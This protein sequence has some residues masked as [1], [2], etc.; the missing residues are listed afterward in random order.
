M[1]TILIFI[2]LL[3]GSVF[4]QN[5]I[6]YYNKINEA[7]Y[8]LLSTKEYAK[9]EALYIEA[10]SLAKP[11]ER[12]YFQVARCYAALGDSINMIKYLKLASV[13]PSFN[14]IIY[15][16]V[17]RDSIL[18]AKYKDQE[19]FQHFL[20]ETTELKE[21][22]KTALQNDPEFRK[23]KDTIHYFLN[24]YQINHKDLQANVKKLT[25]NQR[26]S[27]E[28]IVDV[29]D[30]QMRKK[31]F[32][33]VE[34]NGFPDFVVPGSSITGGDFVSLFLTKMTDK[35]LEKYNP[36]MLEELKKGNLTPFDYA[37]IMDKSLSSKTKDKC[38][39]YSAAKSSKEEC[40]DIAIAER[41]KIGL[42]IY[43]DGSPQN[44]TRG[45]NKKHPWVATKL[46]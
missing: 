26:D 3:S 34:A 35:E 16:R 5:Y 28:K 29:L 8:R 6:P 10:F 43:L 20:K 36:M 38:L 27:V 31:F 42:S 11:F 21:K 37:F 1:R 32:K 24:L 12:D 45:Y 18:F 9:A 2:M 7:D 4:A 19:S 13:N 14:P 17:K 41:L 44:I 40:W 25:I 33:Y 46:K 22:H 30:I 23:K 15:M 39:N